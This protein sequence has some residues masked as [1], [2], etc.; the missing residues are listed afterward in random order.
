MASAFIG[1]PPATQDDYWVVRSLLLAAGLSD[2][3]PNQ[4]AKIPPP[5]PPP[6][7]YRFETKGPAIIAGASISITLMVVVTLTRLLFRWFGPGVRFGADD[8]LIIPGVVC[9]AFS[10]VSPQPVAR[11]QILTDV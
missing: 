1:Q 6:H 11:N 3:D 10:S 8:W 4:G 2:V 9:Y 7:L 5:R